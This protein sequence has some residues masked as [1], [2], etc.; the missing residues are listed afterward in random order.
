V[1]PCRR[2]PVETAGMMPVSGTSV[3][4]RASRAFAPP[5]EGPEEA[6]VAGGTCSHAGA[7]DAAA[8]VACSWNCSVQKLTAADGSIYYAVLDSQ[9]EELGSFG[10][11]ALDFELRSNPQQVETWIQQLR[12]ELLPGLLQLLADEV[13]EQ[14]RRMRAAEER[15]G[16][17]HAPDDYRFFGLPADCPDRDLERAYRRVAARLH[18]DKGGDVA[19]FDAMKKRYERLKAFRAR[20]GVVGG[21][22]SA[23]NAG[24]GGM[25]ADVVDE[26][27]AR[28]AGSGGGAITWDPGNRQSMLL[29]HEELRLQL[30][31]I[32]DRIQSLEAEVA[33]LERRQNRV[34]VLED[35]ETGDAGAAS[36]SHG[37]PAS[38]GPGVRRPRF[39]SEDIGTCFICLERLPADPRQVVNPCA[40]VPQ[41]QCLLHLRCYLF[42]GD[43]SQ[44]H[45]RCMICKGPARPELVQ[46]AELARG[47]MF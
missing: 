15:L 31:Y 25:D 29:A 23:Q 17:A 12:T 42:Q 7:A 16:H 8:A 38:M 9:G 46:Q 33:E 20:G 24:D 1:R 6:A 47:G 39:N 40:S 37:R 36:A 26:G 22:E 43:M 10:P 14:G 21:P 34:E 35:G 3:P 30:I 18:P 5:E 27:E 45:R 19:S 32:A 11:D 28:L 44:Q 4:E 41:C 13:G 2:P